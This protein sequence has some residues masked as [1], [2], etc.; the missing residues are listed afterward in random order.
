MDIEKLFAI[1]ETYLRDFVIYLL[2]VL[3][4]TRE[5]VRLRELTATSPKLWSFALISIALGVF[6]YSGA[7]S[8]GADEPK[9]SA[10]T[11]VSSLWFWF[12]IALAMHLIFRTVDAS[13]SILDSMTLSLK[14]LPVAYVL[15]AFAALTASFVLNLILRYGALAMWVTENA[16]RNYSKAVFLATQAAIISTYLTRHCEP[17]GRFPILQAITLRILIPLIILLIN[18]LIL[19]APNPAAAQSGASQYERL[20]KP[21]PQP[22]REVW[23]FWNRPT[24]DGP[25][26]GLNGLTS[27]PNE[28]KERMI[29]IPDSRPVSAQDRLTLDS[30]SLRDSLKATPAIRDH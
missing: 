12:M 29:G 19:F 2:R 7:V 28:L 18:A 6:V 5:K 11:M 24:G 20:C 22:G 16:N 26:L 4:S 25:P 15:S 9:I 30:K 17:K 14:V 13:E 1:G 3:T 8:N 27:K 21:A 23:C 10:M